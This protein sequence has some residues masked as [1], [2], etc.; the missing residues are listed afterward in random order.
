[1]G[2]RGSNRGPSY[3]SACKAN[4]IP[5]APLLR[6]LLPSVV[7]L[8][9]LVPSFKGEIQ[10]QSSGIWRVGVGGRHS[11]A[12]PPAPLK[13]PSPSPHPFPVVAPPSLACAQ[14]EMPSPEVSSCPCHVASTNGPKNASKKGQDTSLETYQSSQERESCGVGRKLGGAVGSK[15]SGCSPQ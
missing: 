15:C 2:R 13:S 11:L 3:V 10:M 14:T 12:P 9:T 8:S 6:P 1:M 7:S 4:A 5:L